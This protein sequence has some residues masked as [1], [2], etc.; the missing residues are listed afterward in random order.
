MTVSMLNFPSNIL[1]I[2]LANVVI[3]PMQSLRTV[4]SWK[5]FQ[6]LLPIL[7]NH[8]I[9]SKLRGNIFNM[10]VS[11]MLLHGSK[12]WPVVTEDVQWLVTGDSG[13]IRWICG[14]SLKDQI[15]TTDLLLR[16]GLN[17]INDMLC[18]NQLRFHYHL[19]QMHDD[20]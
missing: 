3:V 13:M 5:A 14:V 7:P 17:S 12:T 15:Q 1:V 20:A 6:E 2:Q 4:S 10:C 18:W 9:W 16:L 11:K 19:I 8:A